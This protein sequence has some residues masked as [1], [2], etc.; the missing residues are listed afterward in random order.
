MIAFIESHPQ[1]SALIAALLV[2]LSGLIGH[3]IS[4]FWKRREQNTDH[5]E[6]VVD[7]FRKE[8]DA[9]RDSLED[10]RAQRKALS[11]QVGELKDQV[12]ALQVVSENLRH[13]L[14]RTQ[15]T[16]K[17]FMGWDGRGSAPVV[18]DDV[19]GWLDE[20]AG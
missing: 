8:L 15:K 5:F 11:S 18:P 17:Q 4:N 2:F 19:Q 20:G 1:T 16:L 3:F 14:W 6:A 9:V 13:K 7:G 10:E 12:E